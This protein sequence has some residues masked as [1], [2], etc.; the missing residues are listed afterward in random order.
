MIGRIFQATRLAFIEKSVRLWPEFASGRGASI[1][2]ADIARARAD[3]QPAYNRYVHEVSRADM[4]ASLELSAFLL[5]WCRV[6]K[7]KRLLDLGSG[8]SSYV[9][10]LYASQTVGVY[11]CSVDDDVRWLDRT[12]RFLSDYP[13]T[14]D[15]LVPLADFLEKPSPKHFDLIVHDLNFVEVRIR[16]IDWVVGLAKKGSIIIFDDVH[17][18]DYRITLLRKLR[19][20]RVRVYTL[21]PVTRDRFQRFAY[22]V[23]PDL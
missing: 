20:H 7:P 13:L 3:L 21:E 2:P 1:S 23:V 14:P 6:E 17:K 11:V 5:A 16:Y 22:V 12:R 15:G 10:R 19:S 18:P 8:F 9:F 4:A